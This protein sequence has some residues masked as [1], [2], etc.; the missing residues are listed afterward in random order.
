MHK[1]SIALTLAGVGNGI[2]AVL[3]A[4][5]PEIEAVTP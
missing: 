4:I 2:A 3:P 1:P 5:G